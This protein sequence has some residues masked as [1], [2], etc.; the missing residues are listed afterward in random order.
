M[1]L[2]TAVEKHAHGRPAPPLYGAALDASKCFDRVQW[3]TIWP[4]LERYSLPAPCIQL[5]GQF[6]LTHRRYT[7]IKNQLDPCAWNVSAGLLQGC[8]LSVLCTVTLVATWH[9]SIPETSLAQSYI[10]DRLILS[11]SP[12]HLTEAWEHSEAWNSSSGWQVNK[13]KSVS[14]TTEKH[15]LSLPIPQ[16]AHFSYLGHDVRMGVHLPR[17]QLQKRAQNAAQTS[18]R[19]SR[20]P[21]SVG[22]DLRKFLI[23]TVVGPQWMYGLLSGLTPQYLIRLVD[24][25]IRAAV[26]VRAKSFQSWKI[27]LALI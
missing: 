26:W 9:Q 4:L 23:A 2:L 7:V 5:L 1:S 19:I 11:G 16:V 12:E 18:E 25:Q 10:D 24:Q 22:I 20:L 6:Y 15:R 27:A 17:K 8:P 14:F 13:E 3:S 21:G